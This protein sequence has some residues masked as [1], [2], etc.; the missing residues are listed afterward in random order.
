MKTLNGSD[1]GI[2]L[3]ATSL[4]DHP[5]LM[6]L[7]I[8]QARSTGARILLVHVVP[9][10]LTEKKT[11]S[12]GVR[13]ASESAC[14]A[15][16]EKLA[17]TALRL[18]WQGVLCDSVV[19]IGDPAEQI[20][21]FARLR[22]ANRVIV[23]ARRSRTGIDHLKAPV[24]ARLISE[25][26]IPV[27]VLG[28]HLTVLHGGDGRNGKVILPLS[29]RCNES[30]YVRF[31]TR[32][33]RES[34]SRLMLLHVENTTEMAEQQRMQAQDRA[35]TEMAAVAASEA[36]RRIPIEMAVREGDVARAIVGEAICPHQDLILLV[37]SSAPG[38]PVE[39]RSIISK[40]IADA[41]CPVV[42]VHSSAREKE[43]REPIYASSVVGSRL[44][45]S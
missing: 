5:S 24:A 27:F 36:D 39:Y 32:L 34:S 21:A 2:I 10:S 30:A 35:R 18:Q 12:G 37:T 38:D 7:S 29:L 1:P 41:P 44:R 45:A 17:Y 11:A 9:E 3:V 33:A 15:E 43:E 19:L 25:L 26:E 16:R 8:A 42:V 40:V 14:R 31:A 4:A 20:A 13:I 6:L 22:G 23:G 28:P